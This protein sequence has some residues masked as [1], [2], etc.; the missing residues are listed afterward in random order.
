MLS[1]RGPA[2]SSRS[3]RAS[4]PFTVLGTLHLILGVGSVAAITQ[5]GAVWDR[6]HTDSIRVPM[7]A[8]AL[9]GSLI[10]LTSLIRVWRLRNQPASQWRRR[11][12]KPRE[13][14]LERIQLVLSLVTLALITLEEITHLRT[15]HHV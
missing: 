5:F 15:F 9:V 11:P 3:F 1:P 12:L 6:V 8:F 13:L 2:F 10:S 4:V 14:R 7:L